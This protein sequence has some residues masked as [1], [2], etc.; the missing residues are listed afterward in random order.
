ML[1][2]AFEGSGGLAPGMVPGRRMGTTVRISGRPVPAA[3]LPCVNGSGSFN[4]MAIAVAMQKLTAWWSPAVRAIGEV[5]S[6]P[7][8]F[9]IIGELSLAQ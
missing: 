8:P 6:Q 9:G 7:L 2:V 1:V 3:P 5:R 4:A